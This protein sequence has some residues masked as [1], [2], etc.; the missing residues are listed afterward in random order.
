MLRV[1][2]TPGYGD[3][4]NIQCHIDMVWD[5]QYMRP[6]IGHNQLQAG[7]KIRLCKSAGRRHAGHHASSSGLG[8]DR[9]GIPLRRVACEC[10]Q[11]FSQLLR[12]PL[13]GRSNV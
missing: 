7:L 3:W 4:M 6:D 10:E 5:W 1:Q 9:A 13:G 2:D 8:D 12:L 11:L